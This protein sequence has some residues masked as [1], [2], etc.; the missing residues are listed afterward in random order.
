[1]ASESTDQNQD[2]NET[3]DANDDQTDS[4]TDETTGTDD[5]DEIAA[6]AEKPDVVRR[7]LQAE[8]EKATKARKDAEALA[9]KLKEYED[10]D[11]TDQE[12]LAEERD[13]LKAKVT[14]LE[15]ENLRLRVAVEKKLPG[16]LI[17][18]LRGEDREE[19][20]ADADK[21][22]QLVAK[23]NGSRGS[24]TDQGAR[25]NGGAR[26]VTESELK[27]MSPEEIDKAHREG[28]L[29]DLLGARR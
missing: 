3:T 29:T 19:I 15:L 28:R 27:N 4:K 6:K 25:G 13:T 26:Q 1:M 21:L 8:R 2:T 22:L 16:E 14:P 18:R 24:D 20:E 5:V 9:A 12:R 11:K 17:D 10:R 7:A 23:T